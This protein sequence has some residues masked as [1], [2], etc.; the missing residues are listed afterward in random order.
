MAY[1]TRKRMTR[2]HRPAGRPVSRWNKRQHQAP[3]PTMTGDTDGGCPRGGAVA[4]QSKW[5][6]LWQQLFASR[7]ST[8]GR[9]PGAPFSKAAPPSDQEARSLRPGRKR[10]KKPAAGEAGPPSPDSVTPARQR[11]TTGNTRRMS[12]HRRSALEHVCS[13]PGRTNTPS[14]TARRPAHVPKLFTLRAPQSADRDSSPPPPPPLLPPPPQKQQQHRPPSRQRGCYT[15][16]GPRDA[17]ATAAAAAAGGGGICGASR[18]ASY[19]TARV[20]A[21]GPRC[22]LQISRPRAAADRPRIAEIRR[23]RMTAVGSPLP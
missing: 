14:Q 3:R 22:R 5:T 17:C 11:E 1:N 21:V 6:P 8:S 16:G 19:V 7:Y 12:R 15:A 10:R 20:T 18:S 13:P 23:Q 4:E 9:Q 2:L